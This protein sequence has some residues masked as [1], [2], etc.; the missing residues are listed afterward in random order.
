M[1]KPDQQAARRNFFAVQRRPNATGRASR[2]ESAQAGPCPAPVSTKMLVGVA[3][4]GS[5][6]L[7]RCRGPPGG[8]SG[9]GGGTGP[10]P[11]CTTRTWR[12]AKQG[13]NWNWM[14]PPH[15]HF[16]AARGSAGRPR[17]QYSRQNCKTCCCWL[18]RLSNRQ[19]GERKKKP[20]PPPQNPKRL[21]LARR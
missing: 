16:A 7:T 1:P 12:A 19:R 15:E 18:R 2:K 3:C 10:A 5:I 11:P 8:P 13:R 9:G 20:P 14:D 6:L 21:L 4:N 17:W